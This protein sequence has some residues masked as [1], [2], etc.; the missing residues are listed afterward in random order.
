MSENMYNFP[1]NVFFRRPAIILRAFHLEL[2]SIFS[3]FLH[4]LNG[5]VSRFLISLPRNIGIEQLPLQREVQR[6]IPI[7]RV[8]LIDRPFLAVTSDFV[9]S[10]YALYV[11]CSVTDLNIVH[12]Y[13]KCRIA[14]PC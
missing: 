7:P 13:M 12:C 4:G 5:T 6:P 10:Q 9:F 14:N 1:I 2:C 3:I 8:S 11:I